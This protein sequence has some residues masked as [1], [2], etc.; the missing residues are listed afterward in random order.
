MKAAEDHEGAH[1]L[2]E[3]KRQTLVQV[4]EYEAEIQARL[5]AKDWSGAAEV[6]E[7][8]IAAWAE[9]ELELDEGSEQGDALEGSDTEHSSQGE[10]R[11]DA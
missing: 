3:K 4:A 2:E 9:L 1:A 10:A 5:A 11:E 6:K 8:K 7:K